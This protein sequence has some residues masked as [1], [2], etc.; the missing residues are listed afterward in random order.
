MYT[1]I[2]EQDRGSVYREGLK[3]YSLRKWRKYGGKDGCEPYFDEVT[4]TE[5]YN[6]HPATRVFVDA[7]L[8]PLWPDWRTEADRARM[9]AVDHEFPS[10]M[11]V[12]FGGLEYTLADKP[13]YL[14]EETASKG[15]RIWV[16]ICIGTEQD[17]DAAKQAAQE[18]IEARRAWERNHG[19]KV[20]AVS[21]MRR[22]ATTKYNSALNQRGKV[23]QMLAGWGIET[24]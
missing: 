11:V 15:T 20:N 3:N 17:F 21:G 10:G 6:S 12:Y 13:T 18:E 24:T 19:V 2:I 5:G 14:I 22:F 1:E 23:K 16:N 7:T 4:V 9:G 8:F